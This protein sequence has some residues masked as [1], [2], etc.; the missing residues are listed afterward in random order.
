M[1]ILTNRQNNVYAAVRAAMLAAGLFAHLLLL[2]YFVRRQMHI[3]RMGLSAPA[4]ADAAPAAKLLDKKGRVLVFRSGALGGQELRAGGALYPGDR[5]QTTRGA[6]AVLL[7]GKSTRMALGEN[8]L[9]IAPGPEKDSRVQGNVL[10]V[11]KGNFRI[12][13]DTLSGD[14]AAIQTGN[15]VIKLRVRD[16]VVFRPD[17]AGTADTGMAYLEFLERLYFKTGAAP[18]RRIMANAGKTVAA[19]A[20]ACRRHGEA[21]K[22]AQDRAWRTLNAL[23]ARIQKEQKV[24]ISLSIDDTGADNIRVTG[25]AVQI[26]TSGRT[27]TLSKGDRLRLKPG[28]VP[29][30][31]NLSENA[32]KQMAPPEPEPQPAPQPPAPAAQPPP[33]PALTFQSPR[34]RPAPRKPQPAP[35]SAVKIESMNWQ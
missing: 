28:V 17:R 18:P 9:L 25:G 15:A 6:S 7:L 21:C 5:V 20:R 13:S 35:P 32:A 34:A 22:S 24:S 4:P 29:T 11:T 14:V 30:Q 23:H 12:D 33:R 3:A 16:V 1:E 26:E 8:A 19:A 27:L 2:G 10:R 31:S